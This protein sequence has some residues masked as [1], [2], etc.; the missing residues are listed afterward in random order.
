MR[1]NKK[2]GRINLYLRYVILHT[3]AAVM[4]VS[5]H[6]APC[7]DKFTAQFIAS[8]IHSYHSKSVCFCHASI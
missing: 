7:P 3:D 4:T 6:I 2:I 1:S 8:V 5:W